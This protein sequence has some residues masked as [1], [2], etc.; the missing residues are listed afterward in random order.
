MRSPY[1]LNQLKPIE[2]MGRPTHMKGFIK[3]LTIVLVLII[4]CN[5]FTMKG[6]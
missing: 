3:A 4:I 5:N 1:S 2:K 6:L